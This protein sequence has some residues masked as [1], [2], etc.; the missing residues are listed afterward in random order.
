MDSN[1]SADESDSNDSNDA[2]N[3]SGKDN[4]GTV[5]GIEIAKTDSSDKV[6]EVV[7]SNNAGMKDKQ[8]NVV[9]E[10]GIVVETESFSA[11]AIVISPKV[12][13]EAD[14]G[15][16][17]VNAKDSVATGDTAN[18]W[19]LMGVIGMCLSA[20]ALLYLAFKKKNV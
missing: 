19:I 15:N 17:A 16:T 7:I 1:G 2:N 4:K 3:G 12:T 5:T 10:S 11:Y 14:Q 8:G 13:A 9:A 20:M 18:V 6:S